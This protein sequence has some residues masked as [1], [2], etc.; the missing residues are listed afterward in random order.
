MGMNLF[1]ND[2]SDSLRQ[3]S[4]VAT[5]LTV[6]DQMTCDTKLQKL[7]NLYRMFNNSYE[8]FLKKLKWHG[9][10]DLV[11]VDQ[12]LLLPMWHVAFCKSLMSSHSNESQNVLQLDLNMSLNVFSLIRKE[13]IKWL[14]SFN[15][16]YYFMTLKTLVT[17]LIT[18]L[19][20]FKWLLPYYLKL[21]WVWVHERWWWV[22][23]CWEM[24]RDG[25]VES[26]LERQ[27]QIM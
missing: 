9:I 13:T 19:V 16:Y 11:N 25:W 2:A 6:K 17:E 1:L 23:R 18:S 20:H 22:I 7:S 14:I 3:S 8:A 4:C 26:K 24:Y 10:I 27:N 5:V 12:W 15:W 21:I